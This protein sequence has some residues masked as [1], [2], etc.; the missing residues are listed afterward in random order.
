[1]PLTV[2]KVDQFLTWWKGESASTQKIFDALTDES[3]KTE[4]ADGHRTL[5]RV[6][7]HIVTTYPEM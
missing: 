7:W 4:F 2:D 5:G 3:L 1:M 6:A